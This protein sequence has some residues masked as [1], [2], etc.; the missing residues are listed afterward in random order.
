M[1]RADKAL[2]N[3]KKAVSIIDDD[4]TENAETFTYDNVLRMNDP[5]VM[6]GFLRFVCLGISIPQFR[7]VLI[8]R[9]VDP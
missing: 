3:L 5:K 2:T 9:S 6:R 4:I 7:N 8:N 1:I